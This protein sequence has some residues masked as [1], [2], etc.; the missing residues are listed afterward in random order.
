MFLLTFNYTHRKYKLIFFF[1]NEAFRKQN[2]KIKWSPTPE[3][4]K[5][6]KRKQGRVKINQIKLI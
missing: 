1:T 5:Q 4:K 6:N 2:F 3:P